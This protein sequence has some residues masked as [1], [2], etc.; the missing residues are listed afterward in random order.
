MKRLL[1]TIFALG[2]ACGAFEAAAQDKY[3]SKPIKVIVP[4]APG[5]AVDIVTRIVTEHM[6]QMLG[7]PIVIENK[8]GAF[9]IIAIEQMA[10]ANPDGYTLMFGNNNSNVITPVLYEKKFTI[11]YDRDVV[12]VA[13]V[14]DV[15]G[16]LTVTTNNFSPR[17]F[18]ELIAYAKQNPG[19]LRYGS[20]GVGSFPHYDMEFLARKAGFEAVHIPNKAGASGFLND[21]VS[22]DT[23]VGFINL[24]TTA[25][26][27]R[28]GQLR[29][30]AIITEKRLP[31]FPDL[32]T[33]AELGYPD[34]G[35][36]QLLAMYAPSGVS[37]AI[38][39]TLHAAVV[40][41][42]NAPEIKDKLKLQFMRPSP[43]ASPED[44][45]KWQQDQM[46]LWRRITTEVKVELP[47]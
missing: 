6:R 26:M 7:Q 44:A 27:V 9:G 25:S 42:V 47:E 11:N 19:K 22:G 20:V 1:V 2:L 39:E 37:K 14:A 40:A 3:P 29:Q 17:T 33:M 21:L 41:A 28:A 46:A 8:P 35:T 5:G 12:P 24:A 16:A 45:R 23:Q 30:L 38:L 34:V 36:M 31:E 43:T 10:R 18:A 15:P 32:P 4:Y 13:R